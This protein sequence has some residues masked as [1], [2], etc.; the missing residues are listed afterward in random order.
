MSVFKIIS[1]HL[2][3]CKRFLTKGTREIIYKPESPLQLIVGI[4]GYG[5]SSLLN[6]CSPLPGV[7][8]DYAKGGSKTI[9]LEYGNVEYRLVSDFTSGNKHE[10]WKGSVNLND[11]GTFTI[12]KRL[13][14]T[15][16]RYTQDI[17]NLLMGQVQFTKLSPAQRKEWLVRLSPNDVSYALKVH[18]ELLTRSRNITGAYKHNATKIVE[19]LDQ[20]LSEEVKTEMR[21]EATA[22]LEQSQKLYTVK[23][24]ITDYSESDR[25]EFN[26]LYKNSAGVEELSKASKWLS[27]LQV[28]YDPARKED[29]E[30]LKYELH[31]ANLELRNATAEYDRYEAMV[32]NIAY[33]D[34]RSNYDIELENEQL[35][36]QLSVLPAL[37]DWATPSDPDKAFRTLEAISPTFLDNVMGLNANP[38]KSI[39]N[40]ERLQQTRLK[41]DTLNRESNIRDNHLIRAHARLKEMDEAI[42]IT[43]GKCGHEWKH[44]YSQEE[45]AKI[46]TFIA[47]SEKEAEVT[48]E[49]IKECE[50]YLEQ[51][52]KWDRTYSYIV[53]LVREYPELAFLGDAIMV[54]GMFFDNPGALQY[55]LPQLR[56]F[57][58]GHI[59]R[60]LIQKRVDENTAILQRRLAE[61]SI[62]TENLTTRL[63]E[64]E[65]LIL[66]HQIAVKKTTLEISQ[67]QQGLDIQVRVE[68]LGKHVDTTLN[69]LAE[70][71]RKD[72]QAGFDDVIDC[73]IKSLHIRLAKLTEQINDASAKEA[74]LKHLENTQKELEASRITYGLLLDHISPTGGLIADVLM[75]FINTL[76]AQFN[77]IIRK[78]WSNPLFVMP[79]SLEKGD[80]DYNF[81]IQ[82]IDASYGCSDISQGSDGEQEIINFAFVIL[83]RL[84]LGFTDHPL[85][86]DEVGRSFHERHRANLYSYVKLL[87]ES[88]VVNQVFVISHFESTHNTLVHADINVLDPTGVL[89]T[90]GANKCIVLK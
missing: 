13:V 5:K 40:P 83:A 39:Y 51:Y 2:V 23:T 19:L 27:N 62:N 36:K 60:D 48:T 44:N 76:T 79:C 7:K 70:L 90:P 58:N 41:L 42:A 64:L 47:T 15:E 6:E 17:H 85:Y 46:R 3:L 88:K 72:F 26:N 86:L 8:R 54:S 33:K 31:S 11:G 71:G 55:V 80:L 75:G 37:E 84:Y 73:E 24:N 63:N 77:D 9:I 43:C 35:L 21:D 20:V 49:S 32:N 89:V 38:N 10:F 4:N 81:P 56:N 22:L 16:F 53:M 69:K 18:R 28:K 45:A 1:V 52:D 29:L 14:E 82:S 67:L 74:V 65:Q 30:A 78:I 50:A 12:Q 34:G 66:S 68:A 87:V 25:R 57:V 59:Q 61:A